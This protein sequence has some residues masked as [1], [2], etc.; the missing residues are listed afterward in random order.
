LGGFGDGASGEVDAASAA[1]ALR[2][3]PAKNAA[4]NAAYLKRAMEGLLE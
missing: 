4:P 3:I 1:P 2:T